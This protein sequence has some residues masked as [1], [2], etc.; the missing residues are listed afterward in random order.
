MNIKKPNSFARYG[1]DYVAP[2]TTIDQIVKPSGERYTDREFELMSNVENVMFGENC[3]G[4]NLL[5]PT[6]QTTTVKGVTC[7]NNGDGTYTI[8]CDSTQGGDEVSYSTFKLKAGTYKF[9]GTPSNT[10]DGVRQYVYY[11]DGNETWIDDIGNGHVFTITKDLDI[12]CAFVIT[13]NCNN[14]VFKPM[15]TTDLSATY[16]DFEPYVKSLKQLT[17]N[18]DLL[19]T[20]ASPTSA[21]GAQTISLDLS[22]YKFILIKFL[23]QNSYYS[24]DIAESNNTYLHTS[25]LNIFVDDRTYYTVAR[26]YEVNTNAI[27]FGNGRMKE[28][29][30]TAYNADSFAVPNKIYGVK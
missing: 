2:L 14:L 12:R 10:V 11:N 3:A 1:N 13:N 6:A 25:N 4:K 5:N 24:F 21:F 28:N 15:I 26:S 29:S 17:N 20:N 27:I 7:T 30:G 8:S 9:L 18:M 22:V 23:E 19:W 16:D